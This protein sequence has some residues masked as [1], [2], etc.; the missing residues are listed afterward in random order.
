MDGQDI[1]KVYYR[2]TCVV[3]Q[4][5]FFSEGKPHT[6]PSIDLKDLVPRHIVNLIIIWSTIYFLLAMAIP[7]IFF[8]YFSPHLFQVFMALCM[9][10]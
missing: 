5:F 4:L 10:A 1:L 2:S 6:M 9:Y 8:Q 7:H 3:D